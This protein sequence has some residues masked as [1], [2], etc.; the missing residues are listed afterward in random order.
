MVGYLMSI[1][2]TDIIQAKQW[3]WNYFF[4]IKEYLDRKIKSTGVFAMSELSP[5]ESYGGKHDSSLFILDFFEFCNWLR[6]PN[7]T[8]AKK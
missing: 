3:I 4:D 6:Q 1:T 5:K 2:G 7:V 8:L